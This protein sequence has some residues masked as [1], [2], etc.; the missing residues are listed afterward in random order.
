MFVQSIKKSRNIL[1]TK[2]KKFDRLHSYDICTDVHPKEKNAAI[3]GDRIIGVIPDL[4]QIHYC[5]YKQ[6]EEKII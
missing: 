5:I 3:G 4:L 1:Q 6:H 2:R